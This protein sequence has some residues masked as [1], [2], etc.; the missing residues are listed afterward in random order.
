[1]NNIYK[2]ILSLDQATNKSGWCLV[3]TYKENE[4]KYGLLNLSDIKGDNA[5]DEK[6]INVKEFLKRIVA[7]YHIDLV[8]LEDI[9]QQ[10][11][12]KTFKN[13]SYLQ[14]VLKNY[15]FENNIPFTVLSPSQWRGELGIKGRGRKQQKKNTQAYILDKLGIDAGEDEADAIAL[16][17]ATVSKL[18]KNKLEIVREF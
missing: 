3:N 14:G 18:K 4:I 2:N 15:C 8:V 16:G 10:V 6:I 12:P 9:Q 11:N 1:M 5:L 7:Y 17:I 13:L